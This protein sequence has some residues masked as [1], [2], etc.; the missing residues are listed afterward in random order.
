MGTEQLQRAFASTRTVLAN[1]RDEQ[2]SDPTPCQSWDV[3]QLINHL[4]GS[5]RWYALAAEQGEA[6][7]RSEIDYAAA[8]AL[9]AFDEHTKRSLAA[10]GAAGAEQATLKMPFGDLPGFVVMGISALDAFAHGWDLARATGQDT[11]S[12]DPALAEQL[13]EGARLVA[14]GRRGPDGVAP[15]GAEV[16]VP[17]SA[18]A[19]DRLAA[20]LGRKV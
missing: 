17:D 4:V 6:P 13:L 1:V 2:L 5:I 14:E 16:N 19:A 18:P 20:F 3:R 10:F 12:L 7:E 9:A 15:F 11:A 8:G